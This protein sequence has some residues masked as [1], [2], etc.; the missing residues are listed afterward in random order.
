MLTLK[1]QGIIPATLVFRKAVLAP[2]V[3]WLT[4]NGGQ[5][6][7]QRIH[8]YLAFRSVAN[9]K[10]YNEY[11]SVIVDYCNYRLRAE[12]EEPELIE[13]VRLE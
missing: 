8:A 7:N 13:F 11:G 12:S 3:Q 6:T 5:M 2:W 1:E 10:G 4:K 9:C